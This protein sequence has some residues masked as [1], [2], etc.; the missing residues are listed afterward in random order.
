MMAVAENIKPIYK[1]NPWKFIIWLF[2]ISIVMLFAAFTSAYLVR[3]AEGNWT[4]FEIPTIFYVS[5]GI[6]LI[7]S[8]FMHLSVKAAKQ[9]QIS[10]LK[11]FI[12]TT[13]IFGVVFLGLQILGWKE[14][15]EA[16]IYIK[17]NPAESFYYVL[18]GTHFFH[19]IT[20]LAVLLY[21]LFATFR[22]R[23][24]AENSTQIEVC[25]TYWHF[26]DFLWIYIFIFLIYF[27]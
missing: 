10:K 14:L 26:L 19:I 20:G 7:S 12:T 17:G 21:A 6:L 22:G 9:N 3:R 4:E 15:Q 1:V 27:R 8:L 24:N 25:A 16:G 18:T 11:T 13:F 5:T 23:I 2:I